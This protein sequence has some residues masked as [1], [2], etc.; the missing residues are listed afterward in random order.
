V[1]YA[2]G[3]DTETGKIAKLMQG[4][5]PSKT[6]LDK[7]LD[8]LGKFITYF[9]LSVTAVIFI[10]GLIA[11]TGGVLHNFMTAVAVA[12]AAIPEGMPAVVTIIMAMGVTKM[13]KKNIIIKKLKAVETL[14]GCNYICSDKTGTL[15]ENKMRVVSFF[16]MDNGVGEGKGSAFK[17]MLRCIRA[18]NSVKG[19]RGAYIGDPTEISLINFADENGEEDCFAR[20]LENPFD[21]VRK[22]MSVK[23]KGKE[24]CE[25]QVKGAPEILL[26]RCRFLLDGDGVKVIDQSVKN[27]IKQQIF[28]Y[29]QSGLRVLG[30]AYKVDDGLPAEENL[31]FLGLCAMADG[32]KKGVKEAVAE[33][34]RAGVTTVMIT[35]DSSVT[36]LAIAKKLKI[37]QTEEEVIL[38]EDLDALP[39]T[40]KKEA[41]LKCR[42]FAR[43]TPKHKNYIVKT[44][45]SAGHVVAMTGDGI[46]DAPALKS[47]DIGIAMG[48]GT[49]VTKS[50]AD[51]VIA[52]DNFTTIVSA[53]S[54]GRRIFSNIKKTI[55]F[56]LATNLA[57]VLA[58]LISAIFFTGKSFLLSTQLLWINLITDSLPVLALGV[59]VG[60]ED[61][62]NRPPERAERALFSKNSIVEIVV[63]GLYIAAITIGVFLITLNIWGNEVATT[64]TFLVISFLELF[65]AFNVRQQNFTTLSKR[66]L[67]NKALLIT[68][69]IGVVVN[70]LL[71]LVPPLRDAFSLV[72]INGL[73]WLTVFIFSLSVII[74]GEAFKWLRRVIARKGA[75][76]NNYNK[77]VKAKVFK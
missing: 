62:M 73:Q 18:C 14:G 51:M 54:E 24:K 47:A 25:W 61:I 53:V 29:S 56:F 1:V 71:I 49:D 2:V 12:V 64:V 9:V 60:E 10:S 33:C 38:G 22:L 48:S 20:V 6:P 68:V 66:F 3:M 45:K 21:S 58:I 17:K 34:K 26:E 32:I 16:C 65:H 41:V 70:A 11:S 31:V 23:I 27:K 5:K 44:L 46:N 28:A 40:Q 42:V 74:F 77:K 7:G 57:E 76:K 52:D 30:F 37:A 67:Q 39:P 72:W 8:R 13:S 35:G 75:Y 36:A 43:V 69:G 15:T 19:K 63:Y 4:E 50:A 59:E 55:S